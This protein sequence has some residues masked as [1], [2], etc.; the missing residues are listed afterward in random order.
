MSDELIAKQAKRID[1][2][3]QE[4]EILKRSIKSAKVAIIGIG[5]P[6]NDNINKYNGEQL[7][8]WSKVLDKL[9]SV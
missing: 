8:E 3:E 4:N 9:E 1:E 5:G 2:L 6:L 7:K